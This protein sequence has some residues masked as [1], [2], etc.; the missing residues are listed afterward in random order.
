MTRTERREDGGGS[1]TWL[2]RIACACAEGSCLHLLRP[3]KTAQHAAQRMEHRR[4]ASWLVTAYPRTTSAV[5][6][7]DDAGTEA[8][9]RTREESSG[10]EVASTQCAMRGPLPEEVVS[11]VR[12]RGQIGGSESDPKYPTL[13][14]A[15]KKAK[16][17]IDVRPRGRA[18]S[19]FE[20]V[21]D[22]CR[23][24]CSCK[25]AGEAAVGGGR[26]G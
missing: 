15:L 11:N 2:K 19:V 16:A 13:L 7:V 1:T 3:C 26:I 20:N 14:E 18:H 4:G 22:R 5:C 25:G 21:R 23:A 12:A 8:I 9:K 6:K 17:Q 24:G 10:S